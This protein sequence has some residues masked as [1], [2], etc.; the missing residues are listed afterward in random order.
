MMECRTNIAVRRTVL[1]N[2][3][4]LVGKSV[5]TLS[6]LEEIERV[7]LMSLDKHEA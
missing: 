1:P 4:A 3:D 5:E 7:E 6:S 2:R